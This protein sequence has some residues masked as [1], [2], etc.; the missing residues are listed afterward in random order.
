MKGVKQPGFDDAMNGSE[1]RDRN[2]INENQYFLVA[3]KV[4]N[5]THFGGLLHANLS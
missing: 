4:F 3:I 2:L 5:T 1:G